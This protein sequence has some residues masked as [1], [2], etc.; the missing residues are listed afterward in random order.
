MR[1]G[2]FDHRH[3]A[4]LF[5]PG[6]GHVT[7]VEAVPDCQVEDVARASCQQHAGEQRQSAQSDA[8]SHEEDIGPIDWIL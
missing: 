7:V 4:H 8:S 6:D 1:L 3:V 2:A 5:D